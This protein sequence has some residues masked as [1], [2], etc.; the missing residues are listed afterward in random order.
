MSRSFRFDKVSNERANHVGTYA[1]LINTINIKYVNE[2]LERTPKEK[3]ANLPSSFDLQLSV[4][5][6]HTLNLSRAF[7]VN[8]KQD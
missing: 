4:C 6:F 3:I 5:S 8:A 1:I 7:Q 2:D